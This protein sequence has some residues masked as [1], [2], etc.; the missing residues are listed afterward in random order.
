MFWSLGKQLDTSKFL[1]AL[2]IPYAADL[3]IHVVSSICF[4]GIKEPSV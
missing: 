1:W 2:H 4:G 3:G